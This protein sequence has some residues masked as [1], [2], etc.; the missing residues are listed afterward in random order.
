MLRPPGTIVFLP[1]LFAAC[2]KGD[3]VPA[4]L[5][6]PVISLN[7]GPAQG[8]SSIKATDAWVYADD[9]LL[10]VWELPARVP[11]LR[12]GATRVAVV[13]GVKNNGMYDD[14]LRYPF[15][16]RWE[17]TVDV[18]PGQATAIQ[19]DVGYLAGTQFW[20]EDF[21]DPGTQLVRM[22]GSDTTLLLFTP[23]T[24]PDDLL[25]GTTCGGFVLDASR[26]NVRLRTEVAFSPSAGPLFFEMDYRTDVTLTF[27]IRYVAGGVA[28]TEPYVFISPT[29]R[30]DGSMPWN[31]IYIDLSP[32]FNL[33]GISQRD[34]YL[35]ASLPTGSNLGRGFF[36]NLKVV[37]GG[38]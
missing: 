1:L 28:Y 12:D 33:A 17:Q 22:P 7:A 4:Y 8:G 9:E 21:G 14:R 25:D 24:H 15:Y 34:F 29:L 36:D 11:V 3:K 18:R 5:Y 32:R 13:A 27:G 23:S 30:A 37:R 20:I 6:L 19:P 26:R 38:P 16:T 35:E 31:K 10:G 2:A